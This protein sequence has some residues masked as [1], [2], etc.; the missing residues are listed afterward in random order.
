[1]IGFGE[2]WDASSQTNSAAELTVEPTGSRKHMAPRSSPEE[3]AA[4]CAG[5][6]LIEQCCPGRPRGAQ[7]EGARRVRVGV[8]EQ[9]RGEV[10]PPGPEGVKK[11]EREGRADEEDREHA[12][13]CDSATDPA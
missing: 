5:A 11:R 6:R 2:P 9:R 10:Q 4:C 7:D 3:S 13:D 12:D 1:M 8:V